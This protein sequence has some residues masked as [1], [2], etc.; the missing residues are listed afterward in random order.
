MIFRM[1]PGKVRDEVRADESGAAGDENGCHTAAFQM[2]PFKVAQSWGEHKPIVP[3]VGAEV[4]ESPACI[5][6]GKGDAPAED[7]S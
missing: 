3:S 7:S 2:S 6:P 1:K 4:A 5:A